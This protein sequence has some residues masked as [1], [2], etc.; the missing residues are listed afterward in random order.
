MERRSVLRAVLI[1]ILAYICILPVMIAWSTIL[2]NIRVI[3]RGFLNASVPV[4]YFVLRFG[5]FLTVGLVV[6]RRVAS[7]RVANATLAGVFLAIGVVFVDVAILFL[8]PEWLVK[9]GGDVPPPDEGLFTSVYAPLIWFGLQVVLAAVGGW[10]AKW[11]V[12]V[13]RVDG[14]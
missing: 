14:S 12:K 13:E 5:L 8:G 7:L 6:G 1:G 11:R 3:P 2:D 4:L 9:R 10:I